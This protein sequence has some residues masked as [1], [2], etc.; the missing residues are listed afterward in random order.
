MVSGG[1]IPISYPNYKKNYPVKTRDREKICEFRTN[2][3]SYYVSNR[4]VQSQP[5]STQ[6][7]KP[8]EKNNY[9]TRLYLSK[10]FH[11]IAQKIILY[12]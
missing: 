11:N 12:V 8:I 3:H 9:I 2:Y 5:E 6:V 7:K 4:Q 10:K 1:I